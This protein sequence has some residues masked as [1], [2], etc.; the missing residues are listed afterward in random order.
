MVKCILKFYLGKVKVQLY[1]G[2]IIYAPCH[3][4]EWWNESIAPSF[5]SLALDGSEWSISYP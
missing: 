5:S 2:L 3:E 1:L 4:A